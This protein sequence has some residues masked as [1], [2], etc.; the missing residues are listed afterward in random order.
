MT[1]CSHIYRLRDHRFLLAQHIC[2]SA[3][4]KSNSAG[5]PHS[6]S[7]DASLSHVSV[8]A[9]ISLISCQCGQGSSARHWVVSNLFNWLQLVFNQI[10]W[11]PQPEFGLRDV[12]G[13]NQQ[14]SDVTAWEESDA[15]SLSL[16]LGGHVH[17]ISSFNPST[18][19]G[20]WILHHGS[21]LNYHK[22]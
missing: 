1:W 6:R 9:Y 14:I 15:L 19:M 7:L 4:N 13:C 10:P 18:Y 20:F 2:W 3:P 22:W 5:I 21:T 8:S 16:D 12:T 11:V 17:I